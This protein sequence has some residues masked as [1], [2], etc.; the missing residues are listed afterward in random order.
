MIVT[1]TFHVFRDVPAAPR[2]HSAPERL[3]C[4]DYKF[5]D[6]SI[7]SVSA[8]ASKGKDG[9][10]TIT[11]CNLNPNTAADL[12]CDLQGAKVS[13]ITGRVLTAGNDQAH[14]TFGL[15]RKS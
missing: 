1:P 15:S 13:K 2:R 11:L 14:N 5:G 4:A 12:T 6:N 7:P 10:I 8:S 9:K 3:K